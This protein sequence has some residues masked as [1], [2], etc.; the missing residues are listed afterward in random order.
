MC[1]ARF[2]AFFILT[3]L[4]FIFPASGWS[5]L[6]WDRNW[7]NWWGLI[8]LSLML[9]LVLL[10]CLLSVPAFF[11]WREFKA[12]S[13]T[14][15]GLSLSSCLTPSW[16]PPSRSQSRVNNHVCLP[17]PPPPSLSLP[18]PPS[19]SLPPPPPPYSFVFPPHFVLCMP[20]EESRL[21]TD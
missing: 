16:L 10:I 8:G 6:P 3:S 2:S 14:A 7:H 1:R 19:L 11:W 4:A 20:F 5:G 12:L 13:M 15:R 21:H 17:L 18:P 9:E